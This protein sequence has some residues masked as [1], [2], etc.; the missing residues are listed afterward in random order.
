M[1]GIRASTERH[2]PRSFRVA[3]VAFL[4]IFF[5][6]VVVLV[7]VFLFVFILIRLLTKENIGGPEAIRGVRVEVF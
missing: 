2:V 6:F 5:F 3:V 1:G 7:F 4:I